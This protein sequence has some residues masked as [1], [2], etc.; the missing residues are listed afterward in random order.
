MV[1]WAT[2]SGTDEGLPE[3]RGPAERP[4]M[5][6]ALTPRMTRTRWIWHKLAQLAVFGS[7]W[8]CS[9]E[10]LEQAAE[11]QDTQNTNDAA[12]DSLPLPEDTGSRDAN[13]HADGARFEPR[14]T[15][16]RVLNG[17][18]EA[19]SRYTPC[20]GSYTIAV[21]P[22]AIDST[23]R[24]PTCSKVDCA[25]LGPGEVLTPTAECAVPSC[26]DGRV[27]LAPGAADVEFNWDGTYLTLTQRNCYDPTTFEPGTP[28]LA[29][30]CFGRPAAG[31]YDVQDY[32]CTDHS[33]AYGA[34]ML[35]VE[36]Q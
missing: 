5:R 19:R 9:G 22:A 11:L 32:T 13:E 28:M 20:Y 35:E 24:Q 4:G 3:V 18:E 6:R 23:P 34:P 2:A 26:A 33:F 25:T 36:L 16:I 31:A 21:R 14:A 17:S 15:A 29:R 10:I 12:E 27:D 1:A 30:V 8:A 7:L